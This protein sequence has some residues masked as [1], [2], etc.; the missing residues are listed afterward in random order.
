MQPFVVLLGHERVYGG[1]FLDGE[2]QMAIDFPVARVRV[3]HK[4]AVFHFLP[5]HF[6]F[7]ETDPAVD[8]MAGDDRPGDVPTSMMDHFRQAAM[9]ETAV[10]N[11]KLLQDPRIRAWLTAAGKLR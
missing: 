10:K 11:R 3:E 1:I 4:R 2:S 7:Y 6:P 9:T 8:P 5:V